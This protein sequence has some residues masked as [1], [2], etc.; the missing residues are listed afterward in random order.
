M[1]ALNTTEKFDKIIDARIK[2]GY[3][4]IVVPDNGFNDL[5]FTC[6][7]KERFVELYSK[8]P[9]YRVFAITKRLKL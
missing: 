7:L 9:Y 4:K 5:T 3:F 2:A 8:N 6:Y 1:N